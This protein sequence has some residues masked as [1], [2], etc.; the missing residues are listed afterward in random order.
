MKIG[1]YLS[2]LCQKEK[3]VVLYETPCTVGYS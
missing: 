1:H 2:E 3:R